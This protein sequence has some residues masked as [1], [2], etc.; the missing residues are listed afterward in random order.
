MPSV[1]QNTT[2]GEYQNFVNGVYGKSNERYFELGDM[3]TNI[4]RFSMRALRGIRKGDPTKT[5]LNLLISTSWFMST[6]NKLHI[7]LEDEVWK[8]F[9]HLCSY[10]AS[11]PCVCKET[12]TESRKDIPIDNNKRPVTMG[13]FQLMFER[14]YPSESRTLDQ[15]GIHLAE[16]LG[17]FSEALLAYRGQHKNK[18]FHEVMK[19]SADA[20]SCIIGVF[21]SLK[22]SLPKELSEMFSENCHAC[23]KSPCECE[24]DFI[25]SFES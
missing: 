2:I 18:L 25:V 11:C 1:S 20:F 3:L 22:L 24:F 8:R 13:D 19:E 15:A 7:N 9:P 10:C 14:I 5:R 23:K 6:L 12:K 4:Q 16:E 17:E 21:N